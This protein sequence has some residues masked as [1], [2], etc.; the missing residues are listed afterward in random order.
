MK[1]VESILGKMPEIRK[2]QKKF[3]LKALEAFL[4]VNGRLTFSNMSRYIGAS[5]KTFARQF[6]KYFNFAKFNSIAIELFYGSKKRE[7]AMAFD[8]FYMKKSGEKTYGKGSFW[9]GVS[10]CVEQGLEASLLCVIDLQ[11]RMA[12]PFFAKQTPNSNE[13]K[14][15]RET[16]DGVT[17]IDWFVSFIVS[18]IPSFPKGIKYLLADAYFFKEKFVTGMRNAGLHVICKMRRDAR[19]FTHYSGPQKGR[20]RRKKHDGLVDFDQLTDIATDDPEITLR[21]TTAHS[22]ALGCD[23]L[24]VMP[25]KSQKNGKMVGCLLFST[26][27]TLSPLDVYNFYRARFQI[28]FVIRDA[29]QHT[30]LTDCQSWV[31]E[32]MDFHINLSF[33]AV[34]IARINEYERLE[35]APA[36]ASCSVATQRV[37]YHNEMLIRSIFPMLGLDILEFKSHHAYE[38]ALSFGS[39]PR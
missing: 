22:V 31:K 2:P 32:R 18:M 3:F 4:S 23:V 36:D 37:K 27:T 33:S 5:G 34:N 29:K 17:R 8:P 15:M 30:G 19:L 7:L 26:D 25:R 12:F 10:G 35:N 14:K 9:S 24:V 13:F 39:I 21:A 6:S 1:L 11:H 28:E 16:D 20:G 38:Q